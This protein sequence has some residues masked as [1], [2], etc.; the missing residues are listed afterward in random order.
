MLAGYKL[1]N[2]AA[3]DLIS[4]MLSYRPVDRPSF[5]E[6]LKH[7]YLSSTGEVF[8]FLVIAGNQREIKAKDESS[9]V[10]QDLNSD[11]TDWKE[12]IEPAIMKYLFSSILRPRM[13]DSSWTDCLR[14]IRNIDVHWNWNYQP[15]ETEFRKIGDRE[16][17]FLE[18]FPDLPVRVHKIVRSCDWKERPDFKEYFS[19]E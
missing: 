9:I 19:L 15:Y 4:W 14:F 16:E 13:Y 11:R 3:K 6:A 5:M 12:F 17:Y 1:T 10:V 8:R 18:I 2:P 7:P